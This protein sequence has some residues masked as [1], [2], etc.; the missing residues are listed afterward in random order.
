MCI[1]MC[2]TSYPNLWSRVLEPTRLNSGEPRDN[3]AKM[4]TPRASPPHR[5]DRPYDLG[6]GATGA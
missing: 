1:T 5:Y 4:S 3:P 6:C 2:M